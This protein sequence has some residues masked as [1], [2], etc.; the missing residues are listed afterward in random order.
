VAAVARYLADTSV[1]SRLHRPAVDA[2]VSPLVEAGVVATCG[3]V[4][5]E[6]LWSARNAFE[7]R[8]L[9]TWLAD[10]FEPLSMPDEI[11]DRAVEV[12]AS[13]SRRGA[14]RGV[15]LPD[16]LI[17][18]TAERHDVTLLHYDRDY[19]AVV[20]ATGQAAQWVVTPGTPDA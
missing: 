11:W 6:L 4:E 1:L 13:L 9:R 7:H 10:G 15:P 14:H 5:L 3:I 12:Q 17:A 18:A 20:S 16:L 19:D 8:A 2:A